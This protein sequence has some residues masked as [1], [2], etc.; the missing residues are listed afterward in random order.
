MELDI[1]GENQSSSS[2]KKSRAGAETEGRRRQKLS[3]TT[4]H[5]RYYHHHP[6]PPQRKTPHSHPRSTPPHF[7]PPSQYRPRI[8]VRTDGKR[9]GDISNL[10]EHEQNGPTHS[11][12]RWFSSAPSGAQ[13]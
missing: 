13:S 9:K 3:K 7:P 11:R 1:R 12:A 5:Y 2:I 8:G 6:H 4:L 10:P